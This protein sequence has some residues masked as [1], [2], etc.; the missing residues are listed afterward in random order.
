MPQSIAS[1]SSFLVVNLQRVLGLTALTLALAAP[2]TALAESERGTFF[3]QAAPAGVSIFAA[4]GAGTASFHGDLDVGIHFGADHEG[5]MLGV[6]QAFYA[7]DLNAGATQLRGGYDIAIPLGEMELTLSP[8]AKPGIAYGFEG[9]DPLFAGGL[10][11]EGRFFPIEKNGFFAM[12]RPLDIDV[13]ANGDVVIVPI[14]FAVGAG[15][16]F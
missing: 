16:A 12:A 11:F 13:W 3:V 8:F 7:G 15:Y 14:S 5:G 10:G 2:A 1:S 6:H 9:G 4:D